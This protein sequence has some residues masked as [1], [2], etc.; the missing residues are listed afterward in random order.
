MVPLLGTD[1]VVEALD[2]HDGDAIEHPAC[3]LSH[4]PARPRARERG[5]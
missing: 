3:P 5:C 1:D 2:L 4:P